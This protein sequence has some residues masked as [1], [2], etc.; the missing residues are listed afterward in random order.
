MD[1]AGRREGT[2]RRV[3]YETQ[4]GR[5]VTAPAPRRR[6]H[7]ILRRLLD[8]VTDGVLAT[9]ASG[10][11][12]YSNPALDALVGGD[13]CRP[14]GTSAP[15]TFLPRNEGERYM[16]LVRDFDGNSLPGDV[17]ELDWTLL[18]EDGEPVESAVHVIPVRAFS[19]E[20]TGLL[21]IFHAADHSAGTRAQ[22]YREAIERVG[23][24][25]RELSLPTPAASQRRRVSMSAQLSPREVE[26]FE[27][28]LAGH[29]VA[30][31]AD[32]L[33]LSTHTVR[34]H[35]KSI[36]RKTDVHSQAELIRLA[37]GGNGDGAP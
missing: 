34:N 5:R 11:R 6:E 8:V 4:V 32:V 22:A 15:P 30:T 26:V 24:I 12:T 35:L 1:T 21:W 23:D 20:S 10:A 9:N 29:R 37:K 2:D 27:L 25:V 14:R 28:L 13:A 36:F 33:F 16:R 19:G 18:R 3:R 7:E 17:L 31:I